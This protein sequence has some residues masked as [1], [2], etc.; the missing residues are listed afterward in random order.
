MIE[1]KEK[2]VI[3]LL[4]NYGNAYVIMGTVMQALKRAGADQEYVHKYQ[5]EAMAGDYDHLLQVTMK[6]TEVH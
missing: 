6:Y 4:G 1:P 5:D 3:K 2:P